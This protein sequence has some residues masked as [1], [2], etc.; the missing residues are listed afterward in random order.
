[1]RSYAQKTLDEAFNDSL[2]AAATR[3]TDRFKI[4]GDDFGPGTDER[5]RRLA[6]IPTLRKLALRPM[7]QI[8]GFA[9]LRLPN[10]E[11]LALFGA[12]VTDKGLARLAGTADCEHCALANE[13]H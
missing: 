11:T 5:L 4:V 2:S 9:R 3:R 8:T 12:N 7:S 6:A 1:M 13:S 10:L